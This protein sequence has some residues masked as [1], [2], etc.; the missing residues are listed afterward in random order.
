MS[1]SNIYIVGGGKGGVGK[2]LTS[3]TLIDWLLN[4]KQAANVTLIE[5][6][7][8]NPD[9][10]KAYQKTAEV[11]KE[12]INLDTESGWVKMMNMMP[13]WSKNNTQVVINTA[14]RATPELTKYMPD[15][16]AGANELKIKIHFLWPINRQRDS[17]LLLNNVLK[18][19][20]SLD[21]TVIRNIYF[22]DVEK[23]VLFEASELA[24]K[25]KAINLPELNDFVSDKIYTDRLPLSD[26]D[27]FLFGER[28]ALSRYRNAAYEQ[29]NKLV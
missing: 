11:K 1:K 6:D 14:A 2:T 26:V 12:I 17:L 23:Y 3:I 10:Y 18:E 15:M 5:T 13:E 8:S 20:T 16:Q 7:D 29:F 27:K 19:A 24:K 4:D 21:A 9:V 25:V 28:I 22:G